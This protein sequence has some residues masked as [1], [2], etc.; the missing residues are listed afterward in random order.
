M[1]LSIIIPVYNASIYLQKCVNSILSQADLDI[2]II[3]VDDG[4]SDD[5]GRI[6][7]N[8]SETDSRV[9][10]FHQPNAGASIAR[11]VGLN[12]AS[13]E[14]ISFV[15]ADDWVAP[16]YIRTFKDIKNKADITFF[17]I[18][19]T[20]PNG[21]QKIR[22]LPEKSAVSRDDIEQCLFHLKYGNVGDIFGWTVAKFIRSSIIRDNHIRFV[23]ELVFREDEIFT[24]DVCR[25]VKSVYIL[26]DPLYYYRIIN[27]GL[28][29]QGIQPNDYL[30]LAVNIERNLPFF[31][32]KDFLSNE[33]RRLI[34]Y[35]LTKFRSEVRLRNL[36]KTMRAYHAYLQSNPEYVSLSIIH[37]RY[38]LMLSHSFLV[39]YLLLFFDLLLEAIIGRLK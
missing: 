24:M 34:D 3:L 25:Y 11:N 29:A 35:R 31:C 17:P 9:R 12:H 23:P 32:H 39:S 22:C 13:G 36:H 5:S 10:T 19:E 38:A 26:S 2:E 37:R 8:F 18:Y 14:W 30:L 33:K 4:S 27:T 1:F 28:T 7:D 15:D 6:C 21:E 16:N 20:Y